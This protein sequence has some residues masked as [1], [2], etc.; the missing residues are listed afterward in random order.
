MPTHIGSL[1]N[2]RAGCEFNRLLLTNVSPKSALCAL[3]IQILLILLHIYVWPAPAC[4]RYNSDKDKV[5]EKRNKISERN[6]KDIIAHIFLCS[7]D[8]S[9]LFI[10]Q[11]QTLPLGTSFEIF[12]FPMIQNTSTIAKTEVSDLPRLGTFHPLD[13]ILWTHFKFINECW[14]RHTWRTFYASEKIIHVVVNGHFINILLFPIYLLFTRALCVALWGWTKT[15]L[16]SDS[17]PYTGYIF[18]SHSFILEDN[19]KN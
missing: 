10:S 6:R 1:F 3:F 18:F 7:T 17:C 15:L 19:N 2:K 13:D 11:I 9:E 5:E 16:G 14:H 4:I 12:L 8:I